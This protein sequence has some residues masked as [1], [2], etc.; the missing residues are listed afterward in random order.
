VIVKLFLEVLSRR[1]DL[2]S[3]EKEL[4]IAFKKITRSGNAQSVEFFLKVSKE[5]YFNPARRKSFLQTLLLTAAE[6]VGI[7]VVETVLES[8]KDEIPDNME[9]TILGDAI[10]PISEAE[11]LSCI[12]TLKTLIKGAVRTSNFRCL[13]MC[14][15]TSFHHLNIQLHQSTETYSL[16]TS[17]FGGE[18]QAIS[19][20]LVEMVLD[21]KPAA[22]WG[23]R[24]I[25][26][27]EIE[28]PLL[29]VAG[30]CAN[31]IHIAET[32]LSEGE[33]WECKV[34]Y[35]YMILYAAVKFDDPKMIEM[36]EMILDSSEFPQSW[37]EKALSNA[38]GKIQKLLDARQRPWSSTHDTGFEWE[39]GQTEGSKD[40]S[41]PSVGGRRAGLS[42]RAASAAASL[43]RLR[44]RR[45]R[46]DPP[47]SEYPLQISL[48]PN[49]YGESSHSVRPRPPI[50]EENN[51]YSATYR[52][53][54]PCFS[55]VPFRRPPLPHPYFEN[56]YSA[57]PSIM[58]ENNPYSDAYTAGGAGRR[59]LMHN[60]RFDRA[61]RSYE[62]AFGYIAAAHEV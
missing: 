1:L 35:D 6:G 15:T 25:G 46:A 61:Q 34:K 26:R 17:G 10:R 11:R 39:L 19:R 36:I 50:M 27:D 31:N 42:A 41:A 53:E 23:T 45:V 59:E 30:L 44:P 5:I 8:Y 14:S 21:L 51:P 24:D 29:H 12:S 40:G 49:P 22:P 52:L 16:L 37:K 28:A 57:I 55:E 13:E 18:D 2:P 7:E 38:D 43:K 3:S 62:A 58:E 20:S 56:P 48:S 54:D 60:A 9:G 4:S 47:I 33:H 32:L